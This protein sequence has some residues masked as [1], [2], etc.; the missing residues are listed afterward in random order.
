MAERWALDHG[1]G[2]GTESSGDAEPA[3][4]LDDLHVSVHRDEHG[5]RDSHPRAPCVAPTAPDRLDPTE[6]IKE[7]G[8]ASVLSERGLPS[9]RWRGSWATPIRKWS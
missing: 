3:V 4:L 5:S 2:H 7:L 6:R 8:D 1:V 9:S